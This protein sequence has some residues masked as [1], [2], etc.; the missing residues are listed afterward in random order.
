MIKHFIDSCIDEYARIRLHGVQDENAIVET[1]LF[2]EDV[3]HFT[4][5]DE[6]I[7]SAN[8]G[9]LESIKAFVYKKLNH[10]E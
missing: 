10:L 7:C 3:F 6:E 9:S 2:L 1:A 4:L 8:L 5:T